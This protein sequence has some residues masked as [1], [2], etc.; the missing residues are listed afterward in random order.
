[1]YRSTKSP[2]DPFGATRIAPRIVPRIV[3]R[4]FL[5]VF[6]LDF[7]LA[8]F[9]AMTPSPP[10]LVKIPMYAAENFES[11]LFFNFIE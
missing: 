1:M 7:F 10:L 4:Y 5:L 6:F 2:G 3:P 8:A 9:F 11:T